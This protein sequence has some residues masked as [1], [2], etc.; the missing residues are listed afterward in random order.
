VHF[1]KWGKWEFSN[2]LDIYDDWGFERTV[3]IWVRDCS[4]CGLPKKKKVK[5]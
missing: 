1:H 4:V 5:S 2:L 3:E